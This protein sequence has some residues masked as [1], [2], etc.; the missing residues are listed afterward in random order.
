M[1]YNEK[2]VIMDKDA[3]NRAITRLSYE[4]IERYK[5]IDN[6]C[7]IGIRNKGVLLAQRIYD[8]L[9]KIENGNVLLGVI[10]ITNFRDDKKD[11]TSE[12]KSE[13]Y[14]PFDVNNKKIILVDDVLQTGRSVRAAIDAIM[15]FGRPESISLAVLIDRGHRELPIRA[16]FV[17]KNVPTSKDELVK[18]AMN[19]EDE[20]VFIFERENI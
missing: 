10:D 13:T 1:K 15:N 19:D 2:A 5:G 7:V 12:Q 8:Q 3:I 16:D 6:V 14:L 18:V 20:K 17:G 11:E 9:K 4:I